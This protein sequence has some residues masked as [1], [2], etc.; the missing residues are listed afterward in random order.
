M[1]AR[2]SAF[3]AVTKSRTILNPVLKDEV[4]FLETSS[5]SNGRHTFVEVKLSAGGG[6]PL[7][8]HD[9]FSEEFTCLDGE[10][11][12]QVGEQIIRLQPGESAT[13]PIGSKHRFFNSSQTDCRFQCRI[14][15]GCPGFEQTLQITYGLA[16][17][18][19]TDP[20][21]MPKSLYTLGYIVLIS[22]TYMT[23]WMAALQP[24]LNWFGRKAIKNGTAAELERRYRTIW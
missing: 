12:L 22:G 24:V 21:G 11:S 19:K 23:G 6:N 15:P 9:T 1:Q 7:H 8:Y 14:S 17:D 10:L 4:I 3:T 16:R 13:A 18:G 20:K 2:K 5:E